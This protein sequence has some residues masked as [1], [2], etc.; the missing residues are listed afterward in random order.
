MGQCVYVK[1]AD[2]KS[3]VEVREMRSETWM[4]PAQAGEVLAEDHFANTT[5]GVWFYESDLW[6]KKALRK[7]LLA[8]VD[9]VTK[10]GFLPKYRGPALLN[11][12]R[13][14]VDEAKRRGVKSPAAVRHA[15]AVEEAEA[16][17]SP[18]SKP[19]KGRQ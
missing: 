3:G 17:R 4:V 1:G 7:K 12:A 8:I 16:L 18:R 11:L 13:A 19:R 2:I 6:D 5:M 9:H 10:Q 14:L 15:R